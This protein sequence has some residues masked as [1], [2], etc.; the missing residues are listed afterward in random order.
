MICARVSFLTPSCL[1]SCWGSLKII[2]FSARCAAN[3]AMRPYGRK[4]RFEGMNC[5]QDVRRWKA[6]RGKGVDSENQKGD[7]RNYIR[8]GRGDV[9]EWKEER[10]RDIGKEREEERKREKVEQR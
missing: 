10:F 7:R 3:T 5:F 4:K 9:V 1:R 6:R 8:S 2:T